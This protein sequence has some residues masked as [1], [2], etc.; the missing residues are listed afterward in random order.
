MEKSIID[1]I[2]DLPGQ[3]RD[4]GRTLK[5]FLFSTITINNTEI[6]FWQIL[7]GVGVV[8]LILYSIIKS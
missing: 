7:A 3:L 1:I 6:S 8:G 2:W 4:L 5:T